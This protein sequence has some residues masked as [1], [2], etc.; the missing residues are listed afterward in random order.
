ML[1]LLISLLYTACR[2]QK[3]TKKSLPERLQELSLFSVSKRWRVTWWQCISTFTRRKYWVSKGLLDLEGKGITRTSDWKLKPGTSKLHGF[4]SECDWEL[5]QT[6]KGNGRFSIS[7][8]FHI[9][10]GC[11]SG[12]R[13]LEGQISGLNTA[14]AGWNSLASAIREVNLNDLM[15]P[16]ALKSMNSKCNL[17]PTHTHTNKQLLPRCYPSGDCLVF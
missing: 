1:T 16:L 13:A 2:S 9:K 7:W 14:V 6:T 5:E 8:C 15:V 3:M 12:R 17:Y 10:T 11:L 4:N